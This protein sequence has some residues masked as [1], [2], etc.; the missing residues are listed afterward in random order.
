MLTKNRKEYSHFGMV[1]Y[2]LKPS[3]VQTSSPTLSTMSGHEAFHFYVATE[4]SI[5]YKAVNPSI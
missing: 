5:Y 4:V 2:A 3:G 1:H